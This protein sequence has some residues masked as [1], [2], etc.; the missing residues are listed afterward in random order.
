MSFQFTVDQLAQLIPNNKQPQEWYDALCKFLP[1]YEIDT[2]ERVA[3]FIAQC[4]HESAQFTLLQ[5]NLNYRAESLMRVWPSRFPTLEFANQYAHNPEKIANHVYGGRGG[6]GDEASGDGWKYHGR[7][8]IQLTFKGNYQQ[9]ADSIGMDLSE[10]PDYLLTYDGAIQSACWF[11]QKNGLN[12]FADAG[13]VSGATKRINGG[14]NG[15]AERQA[16]YQKAIAVLS[17]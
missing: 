6:N 13:D 7:G 8:L 11:W 2:L 12:Q 17:A 15:L 9:F 10:V 1:E 4:S 3:A 14:F 16:N 5:E